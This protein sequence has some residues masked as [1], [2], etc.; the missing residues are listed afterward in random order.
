MVEG[1]LESKR[2]RE[3]GGKHDVRGANATAAASPPSLS[4][5]SPPSKHK[6]TK[7]SR[8]VGVG[9]RDDFGADAGHGA[10]LARDLVDACRWGGVAGRWWEVGGS[11]AG[12]GRVECVDVCVFVRV[13]N[14][15]QW[16]GRVGFGAAVDSPARARSRPPTH[17]STAHRMQHTLQR[18]GRRRRRRR[19]VPP[20]ARICS[21]VL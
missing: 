15:E 9:A 12:R 21:A 17:C 16:A 14:G 2:G 18:K 4:P 6:H 19:T 5:L 3:R 20:A 7:R 10:G 8:T 13:A 11:G 1:W